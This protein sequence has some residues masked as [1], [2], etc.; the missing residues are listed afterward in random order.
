MAESCEYP[1][2]GKSEYYVK[3]GT[4][5]IVDYDIC[6]VSDDKA[7]FP[8]SL[9]TEKQNAYMKAYDRVYRFL[10]EDIRRNIVYEGHQQDSV[11]FD[12]KSPDRGDLRRHL[13]LKCSLRT[14][15]QQYMV[16]TALSI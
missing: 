16:L 5:I 6:R 7:A 14:A 15:L 2:G 1:N 4:A 11:R 9:I 13:L 3:G 10:A 8:Y 12:A